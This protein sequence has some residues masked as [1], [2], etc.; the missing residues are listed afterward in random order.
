VTERAPPDLATLPVKNDLST[1]PSDLEEMTTAPPESVAELLEKWQLVTLADDCSVTARAPPDLA[2][3]PVKNDLS[4]APPALEEM[5]IA[6]PEYVAELL[7]KW[8]LATLA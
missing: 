2:T 4:T 7:E 3:F 8:Q 6:P 1:A 5:T